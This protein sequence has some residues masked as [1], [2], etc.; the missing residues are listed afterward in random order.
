[1]Q[2]RP[3]NRLEFARGARP[4]RNGEAPMLAAQPGRSAKSAG[5]A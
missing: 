1:M 2:L 4:T 3:S 5:A